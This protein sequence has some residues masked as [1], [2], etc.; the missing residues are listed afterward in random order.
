[1][2]IGVPVP[3]DI[4]L[5]GPPQAGQAE[6][7]VDAPALGPE[8]GRVVTSTA[9]GFQAVAG[10]PR[11]LHVPV[12]VSDPRRPL[13]IHMAINGHEVA[14]MPVP[15]TPEQ[16]GG[17]VLVALSSNHGGLASLHRLP[18]RVAV[19]YVTGGTLPRSWQE[20]MAVDLLVIRDLDP[21]VL[22]SAQQAAILTWVRL[23]GRLLV[24]ARP[25][26]PLPS[27]LEPVL[28]ATVG[29]ARML[30]S[31]AALSAQY[32]GVFPSHPVMVTALVPHP[33]TRQVASHGVPLIASGRVGWGQAAIWG[34][35]PWQPPFLEW[36]GRLR[37]WDETL[38][39]EPISGVD[40]A[41]LS[42][43]ITTGTP[44][45]PAVHAEVA[46]AIVL[47]IALLL[48]VLRWRPTTAGAAGSLLVVLVGL[49]AFLA[50][51]EITRNRSTTLAQ[52]TVVEPIAE[53][54][55]ARVTT[56][57]VVAVPYGG[58]Y[59][60][61]VSPGVFV[62]PVTP[63]SN[64]RIELSGTGT[65]LTGTLRPGEPPRSFQTVGV[66]PFPASASI[67][68]EGRRLVV[69]LERAHPRHVELRWHERVF[70]LGDL[71]AGQTVREL[72]P[73]GWLPAASDGRTLSEFSARVRD[74]IFRG[75]WGDA[76]LKGTTPVLVGE[77]AEAAP[78]FTLGGAGA[79]GRRLTI[80]VLPLERR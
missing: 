1:V 26:A 74:G 54:G 17:R 38:G 36:S 57:A 9:V 48:A 42:E 28:P 40:P 12:V 55:V 4:L 51:A 27:F 3:L 5:P 20:Y 70:P 29:G 6:L 10:A 66:A 41:A 73:G 76:I 56:L 31:S 34:F 79:P 11:I 50:L 22:D 64:I 46:G 75:P 45:D 30:P 61:A 77:L 14:R 72:P 18:G 49:G 13:L 44:L 71:P 65:V 2:K 53:T 32:G 7:T 52:A 80:L 8:M 47:Y 35:D 60:L 58:R 68:D 19:T 62:N 16:V 33:G 67:A 63:A 59:R 21:A 69:S 24:I 25:D 39:S 43:R 23:G 15:I 37:L 78:V